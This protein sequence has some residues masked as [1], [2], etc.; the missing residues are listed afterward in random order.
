[1]EKLALF[2]GPK[3]VTLDR[4]DPWP[5]IDQD[6]MQAVLELMHSG[7]ISIVDGSGPIGEFEARFTRY[8]GARYGLMH[9]NGTAALHAGLYA[10]GV[11]PGDEVILPSYTWHA[12]AG[13]VV[14]ANA[15]PIFCESHP[16][17]L[18]LAPEDVAER[19]TPRTKAIVVVHMW[20]NV[21]DMDRIMAIAREHD[22]AVVEDCSHAH[23]A[24]WQGQHVGTIGDVG[25]FSL[26][27][28]KVIVAGEGGIL[29]TDNAQFYDRA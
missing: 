11:E 4:D 17:T 23:G 3:A 15:V 24:T 13:G 9:N 7:R 5:I 25:C 16:Q 28:S 21:A 26:Q 20:G 29:I 27:G 14:T 1:M 19:V 18:N 8:T 12:T 2:G 22:L 6:Q 10:V